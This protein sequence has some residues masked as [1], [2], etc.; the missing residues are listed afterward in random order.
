M[1]PKT[2]LFSVSFLYLPSKIR[3]QPMST[4]QSVVAR[5]RNI[6][7]TGLSFDFI[8]DLICK[9]LH[10]HG[11]A[12]LHQLSKQIALSGTIL[13]AILDG[14][15]KKNLVE[16]LAASHNSAGERY[17][18]TDKGRSEA[19]FA[20][21][22]SGYTGPAPV[23]IEQYKKV[24]LAQSVQH[25][26]ITRS[27][28]L[29]AFKEVTIQHTILDQLGPAMHSGRAVMI[30]GLPGTGKTYICKKLTRLLGDSVFLPYA[31]SVGESVV[32]FYD[33][34]VHEQIAESN[35]N[36]NVHL[37]QGYDPRFLKC[38]RPVAVSGGELTLD[39]L[40]IDHDK[41]SRLSQAPLQLKANNGMYI[42]D[43]LGRQ[44]VAPVDLFNRWIVPL[45]EK[46]DYLTL[47]TG[48]RVQV[49]FDVILF[50]S[51][52]INPADLMDEAFLRRLGYKIKFP[53]LNEPEY[54]EIW[55]LY[56]R[57]MNI[58]YTEGLVDELLARYKREGRPLLPCQPRDLLGLIS[59]QCQ[60]A[61]DTGIATSA[62]L[63][64]AWDTYFIN[65]DFAKVD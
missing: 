21:S 15:R 48:K 57:E 34:L 20:L 8:A 11:V 17:A 23:P 19:L 49:P 45:E 55:D 46:H 9:H 5:P 2:E 14:L 25:C 33:P 56:A 13:E 37:H 60:Y 53:P 28:V 24:V 58:S 51:A 39:M 52:N 50:F 54:R 61:G 59:D 3:L 31:I 22:R 62:R 16:I 44:R 26:K 10:V 6:H 63:H 41:N 29:T 64:T 18:L 7:E 47:D 1:T 12:D 38:R 40:E 32:Q 35:D 43:D 42:I 27:D 30:Y 65:L 36:L 4:Q